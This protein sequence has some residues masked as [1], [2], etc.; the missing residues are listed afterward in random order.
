MAGVKIEKIGA[1]DL[2]TGRE[3]ELH[4]ISFSGGGQIDEIV[5]LD[6]GKFERRADG[7]DVELFTV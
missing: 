2:E 6:G 4:S 1:R 5:F 7:E 3:V